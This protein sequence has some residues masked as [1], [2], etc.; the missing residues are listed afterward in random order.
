MDLEEELLAQRRACITAVLGLLLVLGEDLRSSARQLSACPPHRKAFGTG[1]T[2][3]VS[4]IPPTSEAFKEKNMEPFL[5]GQLWEAKYELVKFVLSHLRCGNGLQK[6]LTVVAQ[7]V[8]DRSIELR[9]VQGPCLLLLA[10]LT[11]L[12]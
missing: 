1:R 6:E 12:P 7:I 8:M 9:R 5:C 4:L 3:T 10:P 11:K 2:Q